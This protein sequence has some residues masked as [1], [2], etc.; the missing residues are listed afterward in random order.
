MLAY[1]ILQYLATEDELSTAFV[2]LRRL[3]PK[4]GRALYAANPDPA[5]KEAYFQ[6]AIQPGTPE[7]VKQ[8]IV[9]VTAKTLW[10]GPDRM[11]ALA[12]EQ[13]LEAKALPISKGIWQHFYMYDLVVWHG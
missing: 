3:L 6:A 11:V 4:S 2:A 13:G 10:V 7:D 12:R 9:E 8:K 5:R 1:S